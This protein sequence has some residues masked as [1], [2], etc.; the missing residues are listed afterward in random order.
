MDCGAD[1][2]KVVRDA[3]KCWRYT[4]TAR[5][6][7]A[8]CGAGTLLFAPPY[9]SRTLAREARSSFTADTKLQG[10]PIPESFLTSLGNIQ[11]QTS[12]SK[13]CGFTSVVAR[14]HRRSPVRSD[15]WSDPNRTIGLRPSETPALQ[16]WYILA[17]CRGNPMNTSMPAGRPMHHG[18]VYRPFI[19]PSNPVRYN[20]VENDAN[21][22]ERIGSGTCW[23]K[24]K[25]PSA[26]TK[27][28]VLGP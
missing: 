18:R 5:I 22:G 15:F 28:G 7:L 24:S 9:R 27:V 1:N 8:V 3:R 12:V 4:S 16:G 20:A 2:A 17:R 11:A 6:L 26:G 25:L 13:V 10:G 23:R 19:A 21:G 14:S